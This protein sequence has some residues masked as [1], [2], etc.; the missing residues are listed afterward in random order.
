MMPDQ[1]NVLRLRQK[2]QSKDI[3]V[4]GFDALVKQWEKLISVGG[5]HVEK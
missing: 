4:A 1:V 2:Q 3:Y 5:E